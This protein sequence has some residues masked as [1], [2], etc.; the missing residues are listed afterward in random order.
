VRGKPLSPSSII[1]KAKE[2][3]NE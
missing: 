3:I 1:D 2:L